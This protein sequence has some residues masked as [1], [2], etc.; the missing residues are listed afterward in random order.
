MVA[1]LLATVALGASA[2][3]AGPAG[4]ATA[5]PSPDASGTVWLCRPG[6]APDPCTADLDATVV[7]AS[8]TIT[9]QPARPAIGSP[10]DCFYV[11]PTVSTQPGSNADLRVQRPEVAAAIAQASRFS[12]VCSVW[13]PVY[14]QRTVASL[15]RDLGADPRADAVAYAS[16]LSAW[17]DYM[18]HDNDGRPFVLIGHSQGAAM[19][20]RLV[21][22]VIDP[23]AALRARLVSAIVVGGNVQVPTGRLV[24]GS[25]AHVPGCSS[26]G[27]LGCVIAYSSFPSRPPAASVFGRPGRGVSLQSE[28]T[29]RTGQVLCTNPAALAGGTGS[30]LAYFISPGPGTSSAPWV[31]YPGRYTAR[32]KSGGGATWLEVRANAGDRRPAVTETLGPNWGYHLDDV[33]L[34]LGNLV[35]D[36]HRQEARYLATRH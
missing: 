27:Q 29:T 9:A 13:A 15:A 23:S 1:A 19:L 36:V 5:Q 34:A 22:Q 16:V 31:A 35:D 24:G 26:P 4:A 3:G 17:R 25:F 18:A 2:S 28:Q 14:R 32:C 6:Q 8:G 21:R 20:I 7:S 12:Q 30:L 33:N 10:F 11:Y